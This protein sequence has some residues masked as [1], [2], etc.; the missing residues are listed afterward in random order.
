MI[1]YS[2]YYATRIREA[3]WKIERLSDD[4]LL[5]INT[6]EMVKSFAE[7]YQL[8]LILKDETRSI[9]AEPVNR[10]SVYEDDGDLDFR[11]WS[12]IRVSYPIK[13]FDKI[14]ESLR[15]TPVSQIGLE[16]F[17][18]Y[19]KG[20]IIIEL[21]DRGCAE[22]LKNDL[23]LGTIGDLEEKILRKNQ[24]IQSG[25]RSIVNVL[26]NFIENM[27]T[28]IRNDMSKPKNNQEQRAKKEDEGG[29]WDDDRHERSP[30]DDRS[31]TLN[32]NNPAYDDA[33]DNRA[34][35][36]NPNNPSYQGD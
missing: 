26:T 34:D 32:P 24:E 14:E 28:A 9:T 19:E 8:P 13:H 15:Y 33:R 20:S 30:N 6:D 27:K 25:N 36:L 23:A 3:K 5:Q 31:D 17:E 1:S 4:D 18:D 10:R 22:P 2:E 7:K 11:R 29:D 12:A 16:A 35:Q 21:A